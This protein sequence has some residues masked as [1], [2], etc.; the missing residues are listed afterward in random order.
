MGTEGTLSSAWIRGREARERVRMVCRVVESLPMLSTLSIRRAWISSI[1][2]RFH[3]H[4]S[5][6]SSG[7][8]GAPVPAN[9]PEAGRVARRSL[10]LM[11]T[12]VAGHVAGE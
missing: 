2:E 7:R 1:H 10:A 8:Q 4:S 11:R 3:R 9:P 12:R 6:D 5:R